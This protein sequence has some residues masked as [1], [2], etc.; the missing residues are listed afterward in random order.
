MENKQVDNKTPDAVADQAATV[1]RLKH[2]VAQL[3]R[4]LEETLWMARRYA[5]GRST[6]APGMVNAA[7]DGALALG[8]PVKED[9]IGLNDVKPRMHAHDGQL[10]HWDASKQAFVGR[11]KDT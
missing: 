9:C 7:V 4:Y 2:K 8:V 5:D 3:S 1:A 6:Y 10:G 11:T